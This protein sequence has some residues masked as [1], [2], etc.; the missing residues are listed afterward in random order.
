MPLQPSLYAD[1]SHFYDLLCEDI[2][3]QTQSESFI[4]LQQIFGNGGK[5]HLD[6]ACG[7]GAHIEHFLRAGMQSSG[8]DVN[9]AMLD[10]AAKRCPDSQFHLQ[11]M[12]NI[13]LP[14][15]VDLISCF[16]YSIHY[17]QSINALKQCLLSVHANLTEGGLFCFNAVDKNK[18]DNQLQESHTTNFQEQTLRFTTAWHYSGSGEG[19][20]LHLKI[21]ANSK[22]DKQIWQDNHSMVAFSFAELKQLLSPLFDVLVL[23][24]DYERTQEYQSDAGNAI[25]VCTKKP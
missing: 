12:A 8:L 9:Q 20:E 17:N 6:L 4:R 3:Y 11:D 14:Q 1:L 2:A 23:E 16:L 21:E 5:T 25:F 7:T 13:L 15:P 22:S 18:I 24:H 10:L 19:Q